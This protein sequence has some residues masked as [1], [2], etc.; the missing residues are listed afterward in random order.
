MSTKPFEVEDKDLNEARAK[1]QTGNS[2]VLVLEQNTPRFFVANEVFGYLSWTA[3]LGADPER[4]QIDYGHNVPN[5]IH[6]F[7]VAPNPGGWA[8]MTYRD[9]N[10]VL[11]SSP[12]SGQIFLSVVRP[13]FGTS[14]QHT[15]ILLN[16]RF[17][18]GSTEV[19]ING[20]F[21]NNSD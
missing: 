7:E 6:V 17:G 3:I 5:G 21:V 4:I 15:G 14:Y 19:V 1:A 18:S 9:L 12:V 2:Y 10:G 20:T 11:H 13:E 16:V 8:N